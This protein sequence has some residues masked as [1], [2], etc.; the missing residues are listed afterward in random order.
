MTT[1]LS[2]CAICGAPA[3]FTD[4]APGANPVSYCT[5]D[6]PRHMQAQAAAGELTLVSG[7]TKSALLEEARDKDI[8]GRSTMNKDE[9]ATAV[10][11][12]EATQLEPAADPEPTEMSDAVAAPPDELVDAAADVEPP[13]KAVRR[14]A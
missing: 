10:A 4:S 3:Q 7:Q 13:K 11:V 8:E 12:A 2:K 1:N 6:L 9:L 5:H 14:R